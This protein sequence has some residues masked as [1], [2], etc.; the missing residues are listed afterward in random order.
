[1]ARP[2]VIKTMPQSIKYL[3]R[4]E[5]PILVQVTIPESLLY[6]QLADIFYM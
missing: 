1:M 4:S 6:M 3:V 5:V 2:E